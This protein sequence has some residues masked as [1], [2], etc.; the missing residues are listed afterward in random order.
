MILKF[1]RIP[2]QWISVSRAAIDKDTSLS[3][4]AK[5]ILT[6]LMGRPNNWTPNQKEIAAHAKDKIGSIKAGIKELQNAGYILI[7][8]VRDPE[9]KC[10]IGWEWIVSDCPTK[11]SEYAESQ[12]SAFGYHLKA[13]SQKATFREIDFNNKKECNKKEVVVVSSKD[14]D[15]MASLNADPI[16]QK[17]KIDSTK[18]AEISQNNNNHNYFQ[19]ISLSEEKKEERIAL[20]REQQAQL[21]EK[22]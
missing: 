1:K 12:K 9:K 20:L 16:K 14:P 21:R 3:Y 8:K 4:K 19:S 11:L 2:G 17:N 5:G 22:L 15:S 7:K 6:Y 10:F 13:E 18:R